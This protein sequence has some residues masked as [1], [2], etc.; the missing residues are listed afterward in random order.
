MADVF[1][2][3]E[4]PRARK[5]HRCDQCGRTIQVGEVYRRQGGVWDG[6]MSTSI[7]CLQCE[8]F[9]E[10]LYKLGFEDENSGGYP[11]LPELDGGEVAHCGYSRE[12]EMFRRRWQNDDG[13]LYVYPVSEEQR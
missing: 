3:A 9:A 6:R 13:T 1:F 4:Y 2:S 8:A 5:E 10:A 12:H 11:W 7:C